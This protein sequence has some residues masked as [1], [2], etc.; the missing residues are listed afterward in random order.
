M[1][2]FK[3]EAQRKL[4]WSKKDK[5][6]LPGV[7]LHEW[8]DK[9]H[10]KLPEHVKKKK[11][12]Y[13]PATSQEVEVFVKAAMARYDEI[14]IEPV[15]AKRLFVAKMAATA[16]ALGLAQ[17]KPTNA[18]SL[19]KAAVAHHVKRGMSEADAQIHV[20]NILVKQA[21]LERIAIVKNAVVNGFKN[22]NK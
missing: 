8:A 22:P 20:V 15:L 5:G 11:A 2:P 1:A 7:N 12:G 4:L 18:E 13:A 9:T 6:E 21:H 19:I 10:K 16:E 3:S 14:G 17:R